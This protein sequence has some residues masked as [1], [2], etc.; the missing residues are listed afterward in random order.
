MALLIYA[1]VSR[2]LLI[3][4]LSW[5]W[6]RGRREP[7]YRQALLERLGLMQPSPGPMG[8]I[9]LHAASV[10]EI[11]AI[12]PLLERLILDWPTDSILVSTQ[13]PTGAQALRARWGSRICC[14]FAPLDTP[15]SVKRW[16]DRWQ[17]RVLILT[18]RELWPNCL[19]ECRARALPVVLVNARLSSSTAALYLRWPALMGPIWAQLS[20]VAAA[21]Q[22]SAQRF[23]EIRVT[24]ERLRV[25]GNL[26][27]D[28]PTLAQ[29][30]LGLWPDR[31]G[32]VVGSCHAG[33]EDVLLA[34]WTEV[35]AANPQW[36][37]VLVPRHPQRFEEVAQR[38]SAMGVPFER[39]SQG[40]TGNTSTQVVLVDAM[41]ELG[42]WY[43]WAQVCCIGGTWAPV[44]GHNPLEALAQGKPVVFGPHTENAG[45][46]FGEIEQM[47]LGV[48]TAD[49]PAAWQAIGAWLNS[50]QAL[51]QTQEKAQVW[52]AQQQGA[53]AR[54]W[55]AISNSL[56]RYPSPAVSVHQ[57]G[58]D[59][60]WCEAPHALASS[61]FDEHTQAPSAAPGSGRGQAKLVDVAGDRVVVRHYRRGGWMARWLK[62]WFW[63][64]SVHAGRAMREFV[65]L[66]HLRALGLPVPEPVAARHQQHS[67]GHRCDIAVRWIPHSQNLVERLQAGTVSTGEWSALG[68]AIRR[69][70]NAQVFHSDLN[71]HN[72]LLDDQGQAWVVDFDKCRLRAGEAWKADNLARLHRSL[73]KE[74][75]RVP[76]LQWGESD[77]STLL[78][79]YQ[80]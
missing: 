62:D 31:Q 64:R 69:L 78:A 29:E 43:A 50:G 10:G 30:P 27:F 72:L 38:L 52:M 16:L 61:W 46:L 42:R 49:G 80:A 76:G 33:D 79:A 1:W 51:L 18:E 21:D 56:G 25:T 54:T 13:T 65:L 15:G 20:F 37:L 8:G 47:G 71:A 59:T 63:G 32:I 48:R 68:Q 12:T 7:A 53:A 75:T 19:A 40:L 9:W 39:S 57:Q 6:W 77:W 36:L 26:K 5:F 44:G 23:Q 73:S 74:R 41:G 2:A 35:F 55:G 14:V 60:V 11:H 34:K 67:V 58:N 70:H 45:S 66:R 3:P 28:V 4:V 24:P 17:P 22:A